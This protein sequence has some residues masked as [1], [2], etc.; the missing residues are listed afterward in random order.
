MKKQGI[1]LALAILI[2]ANVNVRVVFAQDGDLQTWSP[3]SAPVG[4]KWN[5]KDARDGKTYPV[6]KLPDGN[7][8]TAKNFEYTEGLE[9]V[10]NN[11]ALPGNA[12][13][14][15]VY[16]YQD[17]KHTDR[18]GVHYGWNAALAVAPKGWH[19]PTPAEAEA[20][21]AA[22]KDLYPNPVSALSLPNDPALD[23]QFWADGKTKSNAT[24]FSA[25]GSG[26]VLADGTTEQLPNFAH[27]WTNEGC[28]IF[29]KDGYLKLE[30]FHAEEYLTLRL[31][32]NAYEEDDYFKVVTPPFTETGV[33]AD[34]AKQGFPDIGWAPEEGVLAYKVTTTIEG[35]LKVTDK[36]H[37]NNIW[38]LIYDS[39]EAVGVSAELVSGDGTASKLVHPGD[40]YIIG[41]M[42]DPSW[43]YPDASVYNEVEPEIT[44]VEGTGFYTISI[45][46]LPYT[47]SDGAISSSPAFTQYSMPWGASDAV[48]YEVNFAT[49]TKLTIDPSAT[50]VL[51]IYDDATAGSWGW[52]ANP[53][54]AET[55]FTY[56]FE[57][58][59]RYYL[60]NT[61]AGGF[62]NTAAY[63]YSISLAATVYDDYFKVVDLPFSE[64]VVYAEEARTG[65]EGGWAPEEGVLAYKVTVTEDGTLKV[66]DNAHPNDMWWL[67]YDSKESAVSDNWGISA[68]DGS[69][70]VKV[71][72]GDYYIVGIMNDASWGYPD[73]SVNNVVETE[74]TFTPSGTPV[75]NW[76]TLD[77]LPFF[78]E[79][80]H[81]ADSPEFDLYSMPWGGSDAI[82]FQ[83]Q[84]ASKTT[85]TIDPSLSLV[86]FIYDD[87]TAGGWS[88]LANPTPGDQTP[89][90]FTFEAGKHYWLVNTFA[91]GYDKNSSYTYSVKV[92]SDGT[93]QSWR[94]PFDYEVG[95]T[96]Y[97]SDERDDK[98][99]PVVLMPDGKVWLAKNLAYTGGFELIPNSENVAGNADGRK[100]IRYQEPDYPERWGVHYGW[101]AAKEACPSG[102]YI[103][104]P[105]EARKLREAVKA[106]YGDDR[107]AINALA[108]PNSEAA[109][110]NYWDD[111]QAGVANYNNATGFNGIGSGSM[112][113]GGNPDHFP[114][115][116]RIWTNEGKFEFGFGGDY[117]NAESF[118]AEE[119]FTI[120]CVKAA[121]PADFRP[122]EG[123]PYSA[124]ETGTFEDKAVEYEGALADSGRSPMLLYTFTPT[125]DGTA[126]ITDNKSN[127]EFFIYD[128]KAKA[129]SLD[130]AAQVTGSGNFDVVKGKA[131]Y[132]IAVLQPGI[133][134]TGAEYDFAVRQTYKPQAPEYDR[135]NWTAVARNGNHPWGGDGVGA[136]NL[137]AGGHPM[138]MLDP[139]PTSG[140]HSRLGTE[141]PQF[142]VIDMKEN[143]PVDSITLTGD[144]WHDIKAYIGTEPPLSHYVVTPYTIDWN[145]PTRVDDYSAWYTP[146]SEALGSTDLS[147]WTPLGSTTVADGEKNAKIEFPETGNTGRYL[148]VL[149]PDN[150]SNGGHTYIDIKDLKVYGKG[151]QTGTGIREIAVAG[152]KP[153]KAV[154]YFD[155][156]GRPVTKNATGFVIKQTV[157]EDNTTG[158]EKFYVREIK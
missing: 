109:G 56:T 60:V 16:R 84:F 116:L 157:Y 57:G 124:H 99:Y 110:F 150:T 8:W 138:L 42:N 128:E 19:V 91:S 88:W 131:Y 76:L 48:V 120:R 17:E 34:L 51:F 61:I 122:L 113:A 142:V 43:G 2:M 12:E 135:A 31:V 32:K 30:T 149:F 35:T 55:P 134:L 70:S 158:I 52:L 66:I 6:V 24:G 107:D 87:D 112:Y 75:S 36:T 74:I 71:T 79:G 22:V 23:Y 82:V 148:V 103:P 3:P 121:D 69:A 93:L 152:D 114:R 95:D 101:N 133:A 49:T 25:I 139:D 18:W 9:L 146:I 100:P 62:D 37:P 10:P 90:D 59:K 28:F 45:D 123:Y 156:M 132:L 15:N 115:L 46:D 5:L 21:I 63:D 20:L 65:F 14:R 127:L 85:L 50:L 68:G 41:I 137:W 92:K 13:G 4:A 145:S 86:L 38:W 67:I 11:I 53:G 54:D 108:M 83:V 125:F 26:S 1:F 96:W 81:G 73:A 154:R 140:W 151:V 97:L 64:S 47:E 136:Q 155:L 104:T 129:G 7:I 153:V 102:W 78:E 39:K 89:F 117:M 27:F 130:A 98:S 106:A 44:F 119:Y 147:S 40:Y 29:G 111:S 105:D 58:G 94:L 141:M 77:R 80:E 144:Y 126:Y 33:Y 72:A 143:L 118:S